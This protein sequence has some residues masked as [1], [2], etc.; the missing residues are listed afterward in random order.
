MN[1]APQHGG[2]PPQPPQYAPAPVPQRRRQGLL[3]TGVILGALFAALWLV[4]TKT[5]PAYQSTTGQ[6]HTLSEVQGI[7]D[8]SLGQFGRLINHQVDAKC[9][10]VDLISNV[11]QIA[12]VIGLILAAACGLALTLPKRAR[13]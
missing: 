7:C 1:Y 8:G 12:G 3:I 13:S 9:G 10:E 6:W 11:T 2:W 4:G 5:L